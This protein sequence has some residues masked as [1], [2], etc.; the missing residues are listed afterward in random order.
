MGRRVINLARQPSPP[1]AELIDLAINASHHPGS[2]T[3]AHYSVVDGRT[4][5]HLNLFQHGSSRI[6]EDSKLRRPLI[7]VVG[8]VWEHD[9]QVGSD[10]KFVEDYTKRIFAGLF[11]N[12][13]SF[14]PSPE[15]FDATQIE[16]GSASRFPSIK[17]KMKRGKYNSVIIF[18]ASSEDYP[19]VLSEYPLCGSGR[20]KLHHLLDEVYGKGVSSDDAGTMLVAFIDK[21]LTAVSNRRLQKLVRENQQAYPQVNLIFPFAEKDDRNFEYEYGALTLFLKNYTSGMGDVESLNAAQ[22]KMA[23]RTREY[24]RA[25]DTMAAIRNSTFLYFQ[26]TKIRISLP[27]DGSYVSK[28][29]PEYSAFPVINQ[30]VTNN[31][32]GLDV[33]NCGRVRKQIISVLFTGMEFLNSSSS[34]ES[35]DFHAELFSIAVSV[36]QFAYE[37]SEPIGEKKLK[38]LFREYMAKPIPFTKKLFKPNTSETKMFRTLCEVRK[39]EHSNPYADL[40]RD[41][42]RILSPDARLDKPFDKFERWLAKLETVRNHQEI[43]EHF[44]HVEGMT[45]YSSLILDAD[46][47][48]WFCAMCHVFHKAHTQDI[49]QPDNINVKTDLWYDHETPYMMLPEK[50]FKELEPL[51]RVQM[52]WC[53]TWIDEEAPF[54]NVRS[55]KLKRQAPWA[56]SLIN[57]LES[58]IR[59]LEDD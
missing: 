14:N 4:L 46:F 39:R 48:N 36:A 20:F 45:A 21:A 42:L 34:K 38:E 23:D 25:T 19:R 13:N 31:P 44:Q 5:P 2:D 47:S 33:E 29:E 26:T 28:I 18:N 17:S 1:V 9:K 43:N 12:L 15:V 22:S 41:Y 51:E 58:M 6:T 37:I 30:L 7:I 59:R 53:R 52:R 50:V 16:P 35:F 27:A 56:S 32:N 54:K 40:S 49:D 57:T 10:R 8:G 55:R 11:G 3:F 24:Y